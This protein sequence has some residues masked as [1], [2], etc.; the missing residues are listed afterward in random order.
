MF[1][2]TVFAY[3]L[4]LALL[5]L[6]AGL[7]V[8]RCGGGF[9]PVALLPSVGAAALIALSQLSTWI[10]ALA[11]ATPYLLLAL[12]LLGFALAPRRELLARLT[13]RR[14]ALPVPLLAYL[15]A[16]A[17][18]LLSGRAGF[19]SFMALSD[20]AVHMIGADYLIHH[21]QSYSHLD[22]R[23]SYGQFIQAYYGTGYPSGADTLLGGSALLLGLPLIWAFQPFCGLILALG[24]GPAW[25]I[26]RRCGLRGG[27]AALAAFTTTVPAIVYGYQ[28]IG[29]VKE[30]VAVVMLLTLGALLA[31][32]RRW[33]ARSPRHAL[34]CAL[35][36]AAGVS[37]LGVGFGAWAFAAGA[38]LLVALVQGV[39]GGQIG[40]GAAWASAA[41]GG[42]VLL[43]AAWPTWRH[44][45][46]SLHVAQNVASTSNSGNLHEPLKWTQ[47]FGVWLRG[48]YK[49]EPVGAAA[50]ATYALIGLTLAACLLGMLQ[51]LR[52]RRIAL[53]GWIGLSVLVWV[54]LSRTATTWVDAKALVLTSPVL[55]LLAWGGVAALRGA[56]AERGDP[57]R[58]RGRRR[59]R[60]SSVAVVCAAL[61]ALALAG[62]A[63]ASDLAQYHSSNLAPT[64]RY[65][66]LASIGKR[67]HGRGPALFTDFDEYSMYVLRKL[68]VGGPDFVYPPRGQGGGLAVAYG[69]PVE[70]DRHL[71]DAL[72]GY[73]L[74]VT[75]RDP[76]AESPPAAY[77]LAWQGLYYDVWARR[78]GAAPAL[79]HVSADE[80]KRPLS[81]AR[82]MRALGMARSHHVRAVAALAPELVRV[83]LRHVRRPPGWGRSHGSLTM[84]RAG[85]AS[86]RFSLPRAGMWELWLQGQ[87]M[88][89]IH[90]AVDG[91]PPDTISGQL[92]GNSLVPDTATSLP[93][94]L[95]AGSHRLTVA[96]GGFS[97]A[98]GDGGAAV[99]AAAFL[100]PA[101]TSARTLVQLPAG[102]SP[103][104]SCAQSYQWI[105]LVSR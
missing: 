101:G 90:V 53:A 17:P 26:A 57:A 46:Q 34:P 8:D 15:L 29:S 58:R 81:C 79:V 20:S 28:L 59:S 18:V 99:L 73:P 1:A 45:S 89:D 9:L 47:A 36:L 12:T 77:A 98:P 10:V 70:L 40:A 3:P 13:A 48:S 33:L 27:W 68:D 2:L 42:L 30:L 22:L 88:P 49:Q 93:V 25:V 39:R 32:Q 19:S 76:S 67:F 55:V 85:T 4:V 60:G 56:P 82:V 5:C 7:A 6:G 35:V 62:G 21:G 80:R 14:W 97:L 51:L 37:A 91:R 54:V 105:E 103:G 16:L 94:S 24:S 66:E 75:R 104:A 38:V 11:P 52:L 78:P 31:V 92:A 63:L 96:R 84:R 87:F 86:L 100:T 74:I 64:A 72:A 65:E 71:P 41:A 61:L 43:L 50:V 44:V 95:A 83:P 102:A 23:N 69:H